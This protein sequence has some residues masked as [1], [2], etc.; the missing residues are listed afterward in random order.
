MPE[1]SV[2]TE[3]LTV[4]YS[5]T[6]VVRDVSFCLP[7][8]ESMLLIGHNGAGKST[9]L[10]TLFGLIKPIKGS[11]RMCGMPIEECSPFRL[12]RSGARFLGQGTR[13]FDHLNIAQHRAILTK[14]YG[15]PVEASDLGINDGPTDRR[16]GALSMGQRRLEAL[17]TLSVGSPRLF[18]LDEPVAGVDPRNAGLIRE[19]IMKRQERG[20]SFIVAEH[21]FRDLLALFPRTLVLRRGAVSY[22]G[23]SEELRADAKLAEVYL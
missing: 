12:V 10:K 7:A 16:V 8:G 14:L 2:S 15:L 20:V 1:T 22:F 13:S 19:W 21:S 4:G 23:S 18:V 5:G 3:L 6:E 11:G 9:L 17:R